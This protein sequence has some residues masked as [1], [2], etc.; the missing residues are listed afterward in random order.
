[1]T[2]IHDAIRHPGDPAGL[3]HWW[4]RTEARSAD[5]VITLSQC[6]ATQLIN[7]NFA[8]SKNVIPLFLPDLCYGAAAGVRRRDVNAP[9]KLLFFGRIL[10]YKGL[11]MLLDAVELLHR[12]GL[13]VHLGVVGAGNIKQYFARLK[14]LDASVLNRW[15]E[16]SE[17]ASLLEDYDAVV[18]PHI[19]C[20]QSAVVAAAHGSSVPVVG[21]PVG[22]MPE[23]IIDG[24][25]GVLAK[26]PSARAFA[27]AIRR[28]ATDEALYERI[29]ASL[30]TS[31]DER[32]MHRFATMMLSAIRPRLPLPLPGPTAQVSKPGQA[33]SPQSSW[34]LWGY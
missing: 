30:R 1:V 20:S 28:L 16:D 18:C 15:V 19:E 7:G 34:P 31:A 2:I 27:N 25:T 11:P 3:I 21:V 32:S 6:V 4:L 12:E 24:L 26:Q 23:Q 5:L 13:R 22:G 33:N 14:A 29:R 17:L 8:A 10:S 9:F